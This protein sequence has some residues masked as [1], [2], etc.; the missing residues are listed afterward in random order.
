M[1]PQQERVVKER[2]EL[3]DKTEKL[4]VFIERSVIHKSLPE[5]EQSRLSRQL[6]VMKLY[7]A[8][9]DERIEALDYLRRNC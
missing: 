3:L 5:E 1:E 9:L 2:D 4:A 6:G 8:I 7:L